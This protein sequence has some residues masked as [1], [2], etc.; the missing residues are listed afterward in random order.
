MVKFLLSSTSMTETRNTSLLMTI[1]KTGTIK[2]PSYTPTSVDLPPA[3]WR[4]SSQTIKYRNLNLD[5][6]RLRFF[7]IEHL[8]W[9]RNCYSIFEV[10]YILIIRFN[11]HRVIATRKKF[12]GLE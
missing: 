12:Q 8:I 4:I 1:G 11:R 7:E 2:L 10:R 3:S 6:E 5:T 9:F